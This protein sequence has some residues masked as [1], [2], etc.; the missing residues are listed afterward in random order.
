MKAGIAGIVFALLGGWMLVFALRSKRKF[1]A[2][3]AWPTAK[4]V[5]LTSE[6]ARFTGQASR[7]ALFVTYAYE[8]HGQK[9]T[10][11]R[12][13]L[14]TVADRSEVEALSALFAEGAEVEVYVEP[15]SGKDS[16]DETHEAVLIPGPPDKPW[17]GVILAGLALL[18]GVAISIGGFSGWLKD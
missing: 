7:S 10:G 6:V 17:S 16:E 5:I 4:G 18:V 11:N 9:L 8:F 13:A 2:S 14:Y 12:L 15:R 3:L 1:N